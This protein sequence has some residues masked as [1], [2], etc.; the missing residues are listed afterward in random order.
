MVQPT[1][2]ARSNGVLQRQVSFSTDKFNLEVTA[3]ELVSIEHALL[4]QHLLSLPS[5]SISH[6][7]T[8]IGDSL[9][10]C[11]D[12]SS[13]S[14]VSASSEDE[15]YPSYSYSAC[16]KA[17]YHTTNRNNTPPSP[18]IVSHES[19][20][21]GEEMAGLADD[22]ICTDED[23]ADYAIDDCSDDNYYADEDYA[24]DTANIEEDTHNGHQW[25]VTSRTLQQLY[26]H[27]YAHIRPAINP[28]VAL[29]D[30]ICPSPDSIQLA[31][32]SIEQTIARCHLI[33]I[34]T[35]GSS[36]VAMITYMQLAIQCQ[37]I[38]NASTETKKSSIRQIYND[39]VVMLK[40]AP[41]ECTFHR[42]HEY[43]CKFIIL[44]AGGLFFLLV[45]IA[46]LE[47]QWKVASMRFAVLYQVAKVLRQPATASG[48]PESSGTPQLITN[49]IIPTIAW[50]RF[51]MPIC[52][53]N[54]F[55]SLFLTSVGVG[56]TLDCTDVLITDKVFD[57]FK[58]HKGISSRLS[59]TL[60]GVNNCRGA[61][62]PIDVTVIQ[63]SYDRK[64]ATNV[65]F[66]AKTNR[67]ENVIWTEGERVKVEAGEV[68]QDINDLHSK[69]NEL[70][71]DGCRTED[72]YL[73]IPMSILQG[74]MAFV[75][76]S[77]PE[78]IRRGPT[79]S[80]LAC[81]DGKE[82]LQMQRKQDYLDDQD[83]DDAPE[84]EHN[85]NYDLEKRAEKI[86]SRPFQCL[87]FSTWNRYS[88]MGADAP[89]HIHPH[90][91]AR[92]DVSRT[93]HMQCLPYASEDILEHQQLYSNVLAAFGELFEWLEHV[94]KTHLPEEYE[95]I[96]E[97]SQNLPGGECSP[98][99][100]FLLLVINLNVTTE[101]HQDRFDKDLCLVLPIG[102]FTGEAL[103]Q[104]EQ[105]LVLE[106]RCGDFV[107]FPSADT[108][109]FNLHYEGMKASFVCH[110]DRGFDKW[111]EGYN[112]W[113]ANNHFH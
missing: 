61:I 7:T 107:V 6:G 15:D 57:Q 35:T 72:R 2:T 63:T 32:G 45:L 34:Q 88:T 76:S 48:N 26:G 67:R 86:L 23:Y 25:R 71:V 50:I 68:V 55:C 74:L 40:D 24:D 73:R 30:P 93:N 110:T 20:S 99:A 42:W 13:D 12:D 100:P 59:S 98:V 80:L 3:A 37:S 43:G 58:Q 39:H 19:L 82:A 69:L 96:V 10:D 22:T 85:A 1:H 18:G 36:L 103:V 17:P 94:M 27:P 66:P 70:Y 112:G 78:V 81:F 5:F 108:T 47:I 77:L 101:A 16:Y 31:G 41:S 49:H 95:V 21:S 75:C 79:S 87:H 4:G 104:F 91:M 109:H 11:N 97:L 29:A 46:G 33:S 52:L 8:L 84:V 28:R 111:K 65:R 53:Q 64:H 90:E 89:T 51:R 102:E 113:A 62:T 83:S 38:I 105:G 14:E 106:L 60:C 54:I 56:E 9:G 44:A 92:V